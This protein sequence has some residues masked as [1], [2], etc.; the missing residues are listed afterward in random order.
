MAQHRSLTLYTHRGAWAGLG[1]SAVLENLAYNRRAVYQL[2]AT[3]VFTLQ[4]STAQIIS[5]RSNS[6]LPFAEV[7]DADSLVAAQLVEKMSL[8]NISLPTDADSLVFTVHTYSRDA[9]EL[10]QNSA[11]PLQVSFVLAP[12][13][14]GATPVSVSLAPVVTRGEGRQAMRLAFPV[15]TFRGQTVSLQ[16]V[17][18]NLDVA[19]S[20]G[21]LIHVYEVID[22]DLSKGGVQPA[23]TMIANAHELHLHIYPNPFN[24]STQIRFT[25]KDAGMVALRIYNL[26]G[27]VVRELS[28]EHRIAGEHLI[29]WDGRDERG[30]AAASGVYFIRFEVGN[31]VQ[32]NKVMLVR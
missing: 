6:T 7:A 13:I 17:L 15:Q 14:V 23:S 21:V 5:G 4:M 22:S 31:E 2:G 26:H 32:V 8:S 20:Q 10:R 30:I 25:M 24:P 29:Q 11:L 3:S 12:A 16:P 1:K 9:G 28:R 18:N 27:Q 19:R